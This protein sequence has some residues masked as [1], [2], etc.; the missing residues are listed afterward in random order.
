L[1]F[2]L[3]S[4]EQSQYIGT[5]TKPKKNRKRKK[6]KQREVFKFEDG[7][8]IVEKSNEHEGKVTVSG[9]SIGQMGSSQKSISTEKR[10][11]KDS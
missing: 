5:T 3:V 11:K 1:Y 6:M 2:Y 8:A 4:N 10:T 7:S 9:S